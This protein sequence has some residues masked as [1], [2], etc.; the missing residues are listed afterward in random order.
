MSWNPLPS[1]LW[2]YLILISIFGTLHQYL[3]QEAY[4]LA[5]A[6]I[7]GSFFYF[8]I[9]FSA[10]LGWVIWKEEMGF[11]QILGGCLLILSGIFVQRA[12]SKTAEEKALLS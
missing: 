7:V 10:I 12:S 3:I 2:G 6:H 11:L 8:S 9:L 1:S 4:R 5:D